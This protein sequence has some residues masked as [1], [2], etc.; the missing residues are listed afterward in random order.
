MNLFPFVLFSLPWDRM[1]QDLLLNFALKRQR[2]ME[3]D[4]KGVRTDRD[5][6]NLDEG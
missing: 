2:K 6:R 4:R 5:M 3:R 1:S